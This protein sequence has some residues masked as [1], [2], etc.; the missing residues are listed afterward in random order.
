MNRSTETLDMKVSNLDRASG[1][2]QRLDGE[3]REDLI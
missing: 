1:I 2:I 3:K